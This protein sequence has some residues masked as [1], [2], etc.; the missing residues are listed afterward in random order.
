MASGSRTCMVEVP[1]S[2]ANVHLCVIVRLWGKARAVLDRVLAIA[3]M[4]AFSLTG[5][6]RSG[7]VHTVYF[8]HVNIMQSNINHL[9]S[10]E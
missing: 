1:A 3:V 6:E 8:E 7:L 2:A 9:C 10:L 4:A 5:S